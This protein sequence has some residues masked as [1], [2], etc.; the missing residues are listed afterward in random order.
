MMSQWGRSVD[1]SCQ[2]KH[3]CTVHSSHNYMRTNVGRIVFATGYNSG[4]TR[5]AT[6]SFRIRTLSPTSTVRTHRAYSDMAGK[7]S[8]K[9]AEDFVEFLNASPTRM[10]CG[11]LARSFT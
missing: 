5:V 8:L 6:A 2:G 11:T 9:R 3:T 7:A 1:I 4:L 10:F